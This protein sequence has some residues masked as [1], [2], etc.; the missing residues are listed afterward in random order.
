MESGDP[1]SHT[2]FRLLSLCHTVMPQYGEG[3][4]YLSF[5][6]A[7]ITNT[8]GSLEY[9]AQSP[10]ENA[11]VSAARN[12]GFVFTERSSRT[13]TIQARGMPEIHELLCILDFNNVRK[14]MSVIVKYEGKIKLYKKQ[15]EEAEEIAA[16]NLAKFRKAQQELEEVEER[17]RVSQLH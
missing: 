12:F 5:H 13:I 3:T 6:I 16:L 7:T 4:Q 11:L 1:H 9:Q 8:E 10:D 2:F 14:R 17:A 15:I